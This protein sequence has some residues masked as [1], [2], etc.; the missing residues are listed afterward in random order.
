MYL[1]LHFFELI[2]WCISS[3]C[4]KLAF[5]PELISEYDWGY[6][7]T[8]GRITK[9]WRSM[10]FEY[11]SRVMVWGSI[12]EE[13]WIFPKPLL[14]CGLQEHEGVPLSFTGA[15]KPKACCRVW[16]WHASNF[17]YFPGVRNN[18][19]TDCSRLDFRVKV[20]IFCITLDCF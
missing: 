9:L 13:G 3:S 11:G 4:L 6:Q 17:I 20:I 2:L 14:L 18:G 10:R 5:Q 16:T 7:S 1:L 19:F 15:L 8:K 12:L